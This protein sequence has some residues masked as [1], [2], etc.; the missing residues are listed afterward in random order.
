MFDA[1]QGVHLRWDYPCRLEKSVAFPCTLQLAATWNKELAAE[2]G[3]SI[4]EECRIGGIHVLLGPGVNIY[5]NSCCGR[6][7]EYMGE[8]PYL[9]SRLVERYIVAI[10]KTGVM[11]TVKHFICNNMEWIR[12][13]SNSV[14]DDR[15]LHEI[16]LPA[17]KAAVDCGVMAL[18]TAYNYLNGEYCGQSKEVITDLLKCELGFKGLVMTDWGS[19]SDG[20]KVAASGQDIEMGR[21]KRLALVKEK[22]LGSPEI[23][24]MAKNII[25]TCISMGFYDNNQVDASCDSRVEHHEQI[26]LRTAREGIVL[27]KNEN[28]LPLNEKNCGKILVT[29]LKADNKPLV[30]KGSGA[31][32]GYANKSYLDA[33]IDKVGPDNVVY[34]RVPSDDEIG[35]AGI[36]IVC[37]GFWNEAEGSDRGFSLSGEQNALIER[38]AALNNKTIVVITAGGGIQMDW[39]DKVPAILHAF[40][41]G[42][43]GAVALADI[44]FGDCNPGGKLPFTIEKLFKDS[45]AGDYLPP[46]HEYYS[47]HYHRGEIISME[48]ISFENKRPYPVDYKEG[49]FVGYRWYEKKKIQVQYCFGYGLS[50]TQFAYR[51][52]QINKSGSCWDVSLKV[53]NTGDREGKEVVQLYIQDDECS[54]VRPVKEL[55][56][57]AK[58]SLEKGEEKEVTM[59]CTRQDMSF[60]DPKSKQWVCEPGTFTVHVGASIEDIRLQGKITV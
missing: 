15:T 40:Y 2:Y 24:G 18:M 56:G 43:F 32:E 9:A 38:C 50:Y 20:E 19:V 49:I 14:V 29:G 10:Q 8:D 36:V 21:G 37:P 6:N 55:K 28:I 39:K 17:F 7:F 23:R 1:S 58:I 26:A 11:A 31:V 54:V 3:K 27:L 47:D 35:S 44:L 16:Y 60:Y 52:L 33:L 42:Q 46:D 25:R 22:L 57:F 53:K 48:T 13:A 34:N 5:R 12:R 30:G 59:S 4:G 45:P 51:A 41:G